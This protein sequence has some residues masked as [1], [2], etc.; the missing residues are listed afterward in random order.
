MAT[1]TIGSLTDI[2]TLLILIVPGFLT[3][4]IINWL[5]SYE[6][7]L[8]QFV[9]TIYS[10]IFSIIIF[11]P[12]SFIFKLNS[13]SDI[14]IHVTEPSFVLVSLAI[15][16]IIGIIVGLVIRFVFQKKVRLDNAWDGFAK[17]LLQR[18][19]IVYTTDD[20]EYKGWIKRVS[21]GKEEKREICLGDP[22]LVKRDDKGNAKLINIGQEILFTESNVKRI[23]RVE[24]K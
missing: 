6:L 23:L 4:R 8:D 18:S 7:K 20:K 11:I 19:V 1:T 15:S 16:T 5:G 9:T 3:F 13:F 14:N 10:L 2:W 12:L 17:S 21:I 24:I 22:K